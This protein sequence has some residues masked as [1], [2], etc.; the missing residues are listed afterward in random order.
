M[1]K[2][3]IAFAIF[4]NAPFEFWPEYLGKTTHIGYSSW[5]L[6]ET[7]LS[8]ILYESET[9]YF[10]FIYLFSSFSTYLYISL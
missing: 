10:D 4:A 3:I 6:Q 8:V 5:C 1:A 9:H 7:S 2:L